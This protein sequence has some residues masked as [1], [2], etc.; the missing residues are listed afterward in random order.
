MSRYEAFA[1][2][3]DEL[4]EDIDYSNWASFLDR[5]M[6]KYGNAPK[7]ICELGC[8][9]GSITVLL[10]N[11]GYEMIGIDLSENM[12]LVAREKAAQSHADILFLHQDMSNYEL[13][14]SVDGFIST[15]DSLNYL[16]AEELA[17]TF[18]LMN[19]YL[20]SGGVFIFDVNT[21]HKFKEY[22]GTKTFAE[23][24]ADYAY[25][26]ENDYD[27]RLKI[28]E[29]RLCFFVQEDKGYERYEEYHREYVHSHDYIEALARKN[30]LKIEAVY[31]GYTEKRADKDTFRA[32][33]VLK[34]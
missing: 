26:W 7:L 6:Q 18:Q 19:N 24:E 16:N 14:G 15:C 3:Y 9:T 23:V 11:K 4:M 28:N 33:Y 8:G 34:K 13:Y 27:D 1:F 22:Y 2:L 21:E 12:L 20:N 29:Y 5:L 30:G 31:D 10:A 25:I 17:Q 32:V